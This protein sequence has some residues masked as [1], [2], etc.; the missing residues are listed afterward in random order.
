MESRRATAPS[1]PYRRHAEW[2]GPCDE[3]SVALSS[4]SIRRST[5]RKPVM[6][7]LE[8]RGRSDR[9]HTGLGPRY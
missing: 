1:V 2:G 8:A 3:R 5:A 6:D 9:A 4:T 7:D